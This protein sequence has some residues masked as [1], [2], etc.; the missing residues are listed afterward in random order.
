MGR[1]QLVNLGLR[2]Y[3]SG[4]LNPG[5]HDGLL[6]TAWLLL[7]SHALTYPYQFHG[8]HPVTYI[9]VFGL[10]PGLRSGLVC[11]VLALLASVVAGRRGG[12]CHTGGM[13]TGPSQRRKIVV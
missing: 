12:S 2:N 9:G 8:N 7:L 1:E 10:I 6:K 11:W 4:G 3:Y 13:I 5:P